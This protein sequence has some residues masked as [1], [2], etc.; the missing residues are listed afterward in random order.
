MTAV[1][2]IQPLYRSFLKVVERWPVD[3]VRPNRDLKQIITTRVEE[4]FRNQNSV[5]ISQA[6]KQ[7]LALEKMVDNEFKNKYPLSEKILNPASNPNYYSKLVS[8]LGAQKDT[9][10][11]FF[12]RLFN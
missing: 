7:L 9:N 10:K 8:A 3:K 6:Q 11:G 4:S 1:K 2:E 5:D 12:A